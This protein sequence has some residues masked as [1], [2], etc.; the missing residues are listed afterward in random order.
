MSKMK[1]IFILLIFSF[2]AC[3][4]N[5]GD[6]R[7]DNNEREIEILIPQGSEKPA[8]FSGN[9]NFKDK[10]ANRLNNE[11]V[12]FIKN[13]EYLNAEKKFIEALKNE[14]DN[15]TILTN[16]GNL[17]KDFGETNKAIEFYNDAIM[18]SD[19]TNFNALYNLG[20]TYCNNGQYRDSEQILKYVIKNFDT[21]DQEAL[22][23]YVLS[24]VY[25]NIDECTNAETSMK[26]AENF[27]LNNSK[28]HSDLHKLKEEI[29]I[30]FEESELVQ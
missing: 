30:C 16:L 2:V 1:F 28:L 10:E 22:A 15:P 21:E 11:G 9:N 26:K 20:L 8:V 25:L 23:Y 18:Y 12:R 7:I 24:K 27:Y 13:G 14:P 17:T 6:E 19:S 29:R 5:S 3:N 4:N